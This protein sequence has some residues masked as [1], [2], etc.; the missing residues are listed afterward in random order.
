M[1]ASTRFVMTLGLAAVSGAL[2]PCAIA[3]PTE[4][5]TFNNG[6]NEPGWEY[7]GPGDVISSMGGNPHWRLRSSGLD[8]FAPQPRT[9]WGVSSLWTGNYRERNVTRIGVDLLTEAVDFSAAERPLS[10]ILVSDNGTPGNF[11]DDW[12]AYTI[13]ATDVPI[14]GEG[15]RTF[16]FD[17]PVRATAPPANWT[18]I[19]FGF[20]S[21]PSPDWNALLQNVSQVRFFYGHPE[22][23]FIFQMWD[24]SLDN[25]L[26]TYCPDD[27]NGDGVVNFAELN[28]VLSAFG[29]VNVPPSPLSPG[30]MN[31]DGVVNF[32]DLNRVLSRFGQSCG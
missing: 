6:T 14:P 15:W 7:G 27:T 1:R 13:G 22:F 19:Q 29:Q 16:L 32:A 17:I 31:G 8:T 10:L 12:G 11:D 25:A 18:I 4:T 24:V 3:R 28:A 2:A 9:G 5:T 21:P 23:F 26:V 30:D 20:K